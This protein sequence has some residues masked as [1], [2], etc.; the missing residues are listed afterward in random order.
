MTLRG[1]A[2]LGGP[3]REPSG[4]YLSLAAADARC[5][6][7]VANSVTPINGLG[8]LLKDPN[9]SDIGPPSPRGQ[10]SVIE[11][12]LAQG[13]DGASGISQIIQWR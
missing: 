5:E 7:A 1:S 10:S 3:Q 13:P 4:P 11:A 6:T 2:G 8:S 12:S 9:H